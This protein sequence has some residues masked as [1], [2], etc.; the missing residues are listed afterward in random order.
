MPERIKIVR[1]TRARR[2]RTQSQLAGA[3]RMWTERELLEL[4]GIG[5][6]T[7]WRWVRDGR[8]PQPVRI[9]PGSKRWPEA[10]I[11]GHLKGLT[12]GSAV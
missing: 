12:S 9:G 8:F 7:L 1:A 6:V 4:L 3:L 10:V 11:A 2:P 5:R